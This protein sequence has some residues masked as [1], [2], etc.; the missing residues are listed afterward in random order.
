V[1]NKLLIFVSSLIGELLPEREAVEKAV[2]EIPLT[3]AWVFE[4]TSASTEPLAESYLRKVRECDIFILLVGKDISEPVRQEYETAL[5][6]DKPR[7]VFLR[8]VE[9]SPEAEA[10]VEEIDVK[11]AKFGT[12][13]ELQQQIQ[14]A[15]TDELIKGYR[16]HR[17]KATE[18]GKLGE[19][20]ERLSEI[21]IVGGDRIQATMG[22]VSGQV[23]VGKDIVQVRDV[24]GE[25]IAIGP[26]TRSTVIKGDGNVIGE[27]SS[28]R[29]VK[30]EIGGQVKD[31]TVITAGRDAISS[32]EG[33][34]LALVFGSF[35]Q[36]LRS[37]PDISSVDKQVIEG[38]VRELEATLSSPEPDLGKVQR[39]RKFLLEKGGWVASAA[40][41]LFSNPSLAAVVEQ[42]AK[43][44]LGR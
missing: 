1:E 4:H 37:R 32:Q 6:H 35:L 15:V 16:R 41:A 34:E 19:F 42:A 22:D 21:T 10:F 26:E 27:G 12:L 31:S 23:G 18:L 20:M 33:D 2:S 43:R 36:E 24:S 7:L 11:W 38:Q 3:R 13:G 30:T 40:G 9:R 17:L 14:E 44:L 28:S 25:G 29:V 39:I 5:A 8:D